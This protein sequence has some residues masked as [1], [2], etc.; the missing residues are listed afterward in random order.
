[1]TEFENFVTTELSKIAST[2]AATRASLEG[3][4]ERLFEGP[5][6]VITTLQKDIG[7][8]QDA[9]KTEVRWERLHNVL[10]YSTGPFLIVLHQIA[11]KLGIAI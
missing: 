8:I 6:S 5:A 2:T 3:L 7:D 9:R 10:H 11:R 4:N 1:M